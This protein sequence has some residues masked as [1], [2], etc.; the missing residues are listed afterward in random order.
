[1]PTVR[2]ATSADREPLVQTIVRAFS[3]DPIWTWIFPKDR[4]VPCAT[5]FATAI[6]EMLL[7]DDEIWVADDYVSGA[8][9]A[10]PGPV[11]DRDAAFAAYLPA[12]AEASG[13]LTRLVAMSR[14]VDAARPNETHWYLSVLG[15]E[16]TRQKTGAATALLTS[17]LERCDASQ[18]AAFLETETMANVGFYQRRGFVVVNECDLPGDGPHLWFMRRAPQ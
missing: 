6:F 3:N 2:R 15:T 12:L 18:T 7:P 8:F 10:P 13:D 5:L 9:W 16:P 14:A 4:Y 1:M 17:V 11:H